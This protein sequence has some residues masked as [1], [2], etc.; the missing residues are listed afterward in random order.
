M[1]IFIRSKNA[2]EATGHRSSRLPTMV[3]P[4]TI[5]IRTNDTSKMKTLQP[6]SV[7]ATRWIAK[8]RVGD[9][10]NLKRIPYTNNMIVAPKIMLDTK[11]GNQKERNHTIAHILWDIHVCAYQRTWDER[12]RIWQCNNMRAKTQSS[13]LKTSLAWGGYINHMAQ[14]TDADQFHFMI[15][16]WEKNAKIERIK[17]RSRQIK[18]LSTINEIKPLTNTNQKIRLQTDYLAENER[19]GTTAGEQVRLRRAING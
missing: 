5:Y 7:T 19:E 8:W 4:S 11:D 17:T 9:G 3:E 12:I 1:V 6:M 10:K 14:H 18:V 15:V 2:N 13:S 16:T